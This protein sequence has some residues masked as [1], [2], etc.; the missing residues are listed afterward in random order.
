MAI[1]NLVHKEKSDINYT[2]SK[3]PDGQQ[4]IKLDYSEGFGLVKKVTIK[5]RLN[6]FMDLELIICAVA[7]LREMYVQE[8]HLYVPYVLGARSDRK[9][10]DGSNNYLKAVI[11]PIINALN[12]DS[13]S[14]LDP[15]SDC[16]EMG[17][18]NFH[19]IDNC[20]FVKWALTKINNKN[21]AQ[22]KTVFV[23]PDAGALKKIYKV[24]DYVYFKGD[25]IVCSKSRDNNGKLSKTIVPLDINKFDKD[26]VIIDDIA[27]G[28]GT[29]IN[30]AKEIFEKR[31]LIPIALPDTNNYGKLYL[32]VTHG[33]FS[34]GFD[35]LSKYFDGIY[36][37]NSYG[38]LYNNVESGVQ[39]VLHDE[40]VGSSD[41]QYYSEI[42]KGL[43]HQ[44]EVF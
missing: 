43:V 33:I 36:C 16:L 39:G 17:L 34:K 25:I 27:D 40:W 13:V 8:I 44:M 23:S 5:S 29:F 12:L 4:N 15:H 9:F 26:I 11:C 37:T 7:S 42:P 28:A 18:N 32:V 30:I 3:Y 31:K 19:K 1:L 20:A 6:N 22:E 41:E 2:V 24:A 38:Q 14:V 35:E 10:E 21:D